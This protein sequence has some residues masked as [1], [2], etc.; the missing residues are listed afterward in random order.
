MHVTNGHASNLE[1]DSLCHDNYLLKLK[2]S[3]CKKHRFK[4][5]EKENVDTIKK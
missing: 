4:G 1:P 3:I 2:A 5:Q